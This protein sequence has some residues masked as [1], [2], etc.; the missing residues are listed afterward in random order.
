MYN[1]LDLV[2]LVAAATCLGLTGAWAVI[3][4]VPRAY[5]W[6]AKVIWAYRASRRVARLQPGWSPAVRRAFLVSFARKRG[7]RTG[8]PG[9]HDAAV[10]GRSL[11]KRTHKARQRARSL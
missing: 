5:R 8:L 9:D 2:V 3:V 10:F 11:V 7:W 6:V 4:W 1:P